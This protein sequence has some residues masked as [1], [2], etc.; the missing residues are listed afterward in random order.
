MEDFLVKIYEVESAARNAQIAALVALVVAILGALVNLYIACQNRKASIKIGRLSAETSKK[1]GELNIGE[2]EKRRFIDT[3]SGQRIEWINKLRDTFVEFNKL[4]HT[5]S[6]Y[7]FS[8]QNKSDFNY[9]G[10]YQ[11]IIAVKNHIELL[12][13]PEELFSENL[14]KYIN[15]LIDSLHSHDFNMENYKENKEVISYIQQVILKSEWKRIKVETEKGRQI[16]NKEMKRIFKKIGKKIDE[17][18]YNKLN[19]FN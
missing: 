18:K 1:I 13:N 19:L 6:M 15:Q 10:I 2:L 17:S 11:E 4:S 16:T 3:I 7:V 8:N 14:M 5:Y 12:L 9:G